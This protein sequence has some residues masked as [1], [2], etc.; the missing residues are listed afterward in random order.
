MRRPIPFP[1]SRSTANIQQQKLLEEQLNA[2]AEIVGAS[3]APKKKLFQGMSD[4][5]SLAKRKITKHPGSN[6]SFGFA[7]K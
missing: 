3:E 1:V 7:G 5:A 6:K 2:E 4:S